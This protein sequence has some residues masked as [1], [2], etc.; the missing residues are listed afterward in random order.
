MNLKYFIKGQRG[1]TM[2]EMMVAIIIFGV[3]AG[4]CGL[5]LQQIVTVPEKGDTQVDALHELQNVIHWVGLDVG[6]AKT[7]VDGDDLT[8]TMP[9]DSVVSYIR[10]GDILYRNCDGD[11]LVVARHIS[12]MDFTLSGRVITINITSTP[13][14]RWGVSENR[15]CQLTMRPSG[16]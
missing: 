11:S 13:E 6:S 12:S 14:S 8:L 4:A 2:V 7:A 1:Y 16:T 15:T 10:T 3:I 5:A 9:D